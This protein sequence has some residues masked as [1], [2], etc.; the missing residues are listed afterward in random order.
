MAYAF[1]DAMIRDFF[2]RRKEL[3]AHNRTVLKNPHSKYRDASLRGF[4]FTLGKK[5][6]TWFVNGGKPRRQVVLGYYPSMPYA[7]AKRLAKQLQGEWRPK[8][9]YKWT[10]RRT[11]VYRR[12]Q[13][14]KLR[15]ENGLIDR[16]FA[17][18]LSPLATMRI[19][20]ISA[21]RVQSRHERWRRLRT[22]MRID[23]EDRREPQ[24]AS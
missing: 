12:L 15:Q 7:T 9:P 1:D 6:L 11:A 10:D 17:E 19:T 2:D 21:G 23:V 8:K 20:Q 24:V 22:E 13:N 16:C 5:R 14:A 3:Y 18:G 4:G